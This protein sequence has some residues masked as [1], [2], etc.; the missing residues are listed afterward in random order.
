MSTTPKKTRKT[1]PLAID[2][3]LPVTPDSQK[4]QKIAKA[5]ST[6]VL[7]CGSVGAL[8]QQEE[9]VSPATP[10]SGKR[11]K[12]KTAFPV[13]R[14]KRIMQADE[15]VGK[16]SSTVP[17]M[18]S[19]CLE[20]FMRDLVLKAQKVTREKFARTLTVAHLYVWEQCVHVIM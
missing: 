5:Q 11:R 3:S 15:E 20:L 7:A 10:G 19:K 12:F 4:T 8:Q 14:I 17:L 13:A 18:I 9:P 2:T 1:I 6:E 16:I